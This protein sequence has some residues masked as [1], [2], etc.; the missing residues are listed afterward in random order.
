[1]AGTSFDI[2][3]IG[4]GIAGLTAAHHAALAGVSVAHFIADGM[5][6]GL[7]MNVGALDGWPAAGAVGGAELAAGLLGRNE[8]LG[9]SLVP[10]R[11]DKVEGA[12]A[13]TLSGPDGTWRA[14]QVIVATGAS[15]RTLDAPGA[16]RLAGRGVSQCAWCDGG[17]YRDAEVVVAGGGDAALSEAIHLAEFARSVTIVTRGEMFRARRSYVSR[18]ADDER[19]KLRWAS[20]I[21]E[22][23]G[24]K[25]VEGV[26]VRDNEAGN[27]EVVACNGLFVFVGLAPNAGLLPADVARDERGFV[28][29]DAD[30]RDG[31][32]RRIRRR[33]RALGLWRPA[34]PG[35]R[36][37]D[38]RRRTSGGALR[39]LGSTIAK[40]TTVTP[41][42]A[43]GLW[44]ARKVPRCAR[45]DVR[46]SGRLSV[47]AR[48]SRLNAASPSTGP[49]ASITKTY[50]GPAVSISQASNAI[51][52][53]VIE[54]PMQLAI[55]SAEPTSVGGAK[56]ALSAENCGELPA[57][58]RPQNKR[59]AR[60][61]GKGAR[62]A[63]G[64]TRQHRP[65]ADNC[66]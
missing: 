39:R 42:A 65:D 1:M 21:V 44:G 19:F 14:K 34:D 64:E 41:S 2:A 47:A 40:E 22:V 31:H 38:H 66:I 27:E 59:K 29:T 28:V 45:D 37:G 56:R 49:G 3:V 50:C 26:R 43:R 18:V 46:M 63:S 12:A 7:V 11:I 25:G 4:G 58:T 17:L 30:L 60:K 52:T 10:S 48:T 54:K 55:V 5:P 24:D 15:L 53:I 36:R 33:R 13:K 51:E 62:N 9:V 16:E 20:E 61:S 35:R 57:T 8:E 32:T 6:G 23:L